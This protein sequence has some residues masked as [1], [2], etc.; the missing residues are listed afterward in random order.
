MKTT[1]KRSSTLQRTLKSGFSSRRHLFT[2]IELLV[3]IA[4]IAI[5]AGMLLPALNSAREKARAA[6]CQSNIG[7][8]VKGWIYYSGD[9]QDWSMPMNRG[10]LGPG[11]SRQDWDLWTHRLYTDYKITHQTFFCPTARPLYAYPFDTVN[12]STGRKW[13]EKDMLENAFGFAYYVS[14]GYTSPHF[15]GYNYSTSLRTDMIKFSSIKSPSTKIPFSESGVN[16]NGTQG[17]QGCAAVNDS[18]AGSRFGNIANPHG[19]NQQ[20]WSA[21]KGNSNHGY[22]DGH[23]GMVMNPHQ[24]F[25]RAEFK[26]WLPEGGW[27]YR[28]F[29][30]F[31]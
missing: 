16:T 25:I 18:I 3:V 5:L 31:L 19:L 26:K 11:Q 13:T 30:P 27:G 22:A 24:Y 12:T 8:I 17:R 7:Q 14:Y 6:S 28:P 10:S 21:L 23:V 15:G 9:H 20:L 4:I 2:L 1:W 29:R